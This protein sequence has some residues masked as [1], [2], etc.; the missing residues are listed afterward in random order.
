M[1]AVERL[2]VHVRLAAAA[3][4]EAEDDVVLARGVVGDDA[5]L[6]VGQPGAGALGQIALQAAAAQRAE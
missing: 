6:H 5:R 2:D 1:V 3:E 4:P